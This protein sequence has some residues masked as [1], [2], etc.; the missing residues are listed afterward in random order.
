VNDY[1]ALS[2]VTINKPALPKT[3]FAPGRV[4]TV[5]AQPKEKEYR[6]MDTLTLEIP[7]LG[8]NLPVVGISIT[9]QGWDLTWLS[10]Q[11]GWLDG[12]LMGNT[13]ITA[14]TFLADGTPSPFVN[15]GSLYIW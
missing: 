12:T 14:H 15:L 8:V 5:S 1:V 7:S 13:G 4:T 6:Q 11:A 2:N 3:G 9:D 10:N